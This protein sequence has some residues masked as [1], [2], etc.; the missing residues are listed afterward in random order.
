MT[1]GLMRTISTPNTSF[2]RWKSFLVHTHRL[3]VAPVPALRQRPQSR[4]LAQVRPE[5]FSE[6][7]FAPSSPSRGP[8]DELLGPSTGL[9]ADGGDHKPPDERILKLGKSEFATILLDLPMDA[10]NLSASHIVTATPKH[11]ENSTSAGDI[12]PIHIIAPVSI[13]TSTFAGCQGP[14]GISS[15]FMDSTGS[16]GMCTHCGKREAYNCVR[17]DCQDG[18][19]HLSSA[20]RES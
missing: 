8:A 12:V 2:L 20:G 5:P 13:D 1:S 14:D 10:D 19:H 7:W 9:A 4:S 6:L 17:E 16:M 15:S 11:P 18:L 3:L